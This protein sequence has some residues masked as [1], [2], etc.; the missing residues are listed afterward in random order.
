MEMTMEMMMEMRMDMMMEIDVPYDARIVLVN[1]IYAM[2]I[3]QITYHVT[4]CNISQL[5]HKY[6]CVIVEDFF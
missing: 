3:I 6:I 5:A 4:A 2:Y 1:V